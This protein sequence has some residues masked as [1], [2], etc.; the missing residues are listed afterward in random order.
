MNKSRAVSTPKKNNQN[1][2]K[3]VN[4]ITEKAKKFL[5]NSEKFKQK[6]P[7]NFQSNFLSLEFLKS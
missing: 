6:I 4:L 1:H 7:E 2:Q 5:K 3:T